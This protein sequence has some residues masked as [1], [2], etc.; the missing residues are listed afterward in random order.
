MC[1]LRVLSVAAP[2]L[3]RSLRRSHALTSPAPLS[4][5]NA[6]VLA[7][8]ATANSSSSWSDSNWACGRAERSRFV[9]LMNSWEDDLER[10]L[11]AISEVEPNLLLIGA[12]SLCMPGAIQC[13][14]IARMILGDRVFIVLGGRHVSETFFLNRSGTVSHH[15]ASPLRLMKEDTIPDLFDIVVAGQGEGIVE[16]IGET[17]GRETCPSFDESSKRRIFES[18]RDADG[19]WLAGRLESNK[20]EIIQSLG[21]SINKS[22]VPDA[23]TM[24]GTTGS[25]SVFPGR[26]TAQL[27][28]SARNG[29]VYNCSYCSEAHNNSVGETLNNYSA[30]RVLD[31]LTVASGVLGEDWPVFGQSAFIEDSM[32]LGGSGKLMRDLD[33]LLHTKPINIAFG[34]QLT[35]DAIVD[36]IAYLKELQKTG[37]KYIFSGIETMTPEMIVGHMAKAKNGLLPWRRRVEIALELLCEASINFGCSLLFG[38]GESQ[39]K[40]LEMLYFL[41]RQR[42][43]TGLP[44]VVS[45]NWAVQHPMHGLDRGANYLYLDWGIPDGWEDCFR[46][47]GEASVR[48]GIPQVPAPTQGELIEINQA[49]AELHLWR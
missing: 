27:W 13:A 26:M 47:F 46:D 31:S 43:V 35:I 45:M 15:P 1:S 4:I 33:N 48:Y 22:T 40:R 41:H 16:K 12:M 32:F 11:L 42:V 34:G 44:S 29:C 19:I 30:Q 18:L 3:K 23:V 5:Q 38:L 9:L 37:L 39:E 49:I 2:H 28:T 17:I 8:A 10:Y 14:K 36:R 6:T 7:A 20:V 25:F 24:F 21:K